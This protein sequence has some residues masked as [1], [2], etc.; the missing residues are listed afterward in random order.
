[1]RPAGEFEDC[2]G[3]DMVKLQRFY[4]DEPFVFFFVLVLREVWFT[5][6]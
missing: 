6:M 1:L 4:S 5:F 3:A 2:V